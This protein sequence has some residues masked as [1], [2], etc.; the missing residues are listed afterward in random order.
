[1]LTHPHVRP[2]RAVLEDVTDTTK[3]RRYGRNI[4]AVDEDAAARDRQEPGDRAQDVRLSR[5]RRAEEREELAVADVLRDPADAGRNAAAGI[6][7]IE[8]DVDERPLGH[9]HARAPI[10][11]V[12]TSGTHASPIDASKT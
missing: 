4:V 6:E 7:L 5:F 8:P 3:A 11:R 10:S 9:A 1:M 2:E 12:R